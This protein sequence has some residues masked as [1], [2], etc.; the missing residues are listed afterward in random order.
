MLIRFKEKSKW[1][2]HPA[3]NIIRSKTSG[4]PVEETEETLKRSRRSAP[5]KPVSF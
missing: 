2:V 3:Q 4:W 1:D 5:L